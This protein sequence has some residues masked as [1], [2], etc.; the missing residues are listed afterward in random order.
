MDE[1]E[2]KTPPAVPA[3]A[4]GDA[5][6]EAKH[7]LNEVE[8]P[9]IAPAQEA[10][11]AAAE[12]V[13]SLGAMALE[14]GVQP[15]DD[16]RGVRD[17]VPFIVAARE[18]AA[19][20][21]SSAASA[22]A[23]TRRRFSRFTLLAASLVV[24]AA[25]GAMG[26][27]LGATSV[28]R[29]ASDPTPAAAPDSTVALQSALTQLKSEVA[30]LKA[31]VDA[32]SRSS[33]AQY[34][35]LVDRFDRAERAQAAAPKADALTKDATAATA[36]KDVTGSVTPANPAASPAPVAPLPQ[37][38]TAPGAIVPGWSVRDVYRGVAMLQSHLGGMVEVA[39]GDVLPSLGRIEAIR[40]QD[41]RWVVV[42]SR[43]M[44]V[45]MR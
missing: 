33:T 43:G 30:A 19:S 36:A 32:T 1:S 11:P 29:L 42:T 6:A 5:A 13:D 38:A 35:R 37:V 41:G 16:D 23:S 17:I 3:S 18:R 4:A 34:N 9:A 20:A 21:A 45:S 26:G 27:V 7:E 24:A 10:T 8:S 15:S 22:S 28:A 39:P 2:Q 44:I 25:V 31:G 12:A 14:D 40:R